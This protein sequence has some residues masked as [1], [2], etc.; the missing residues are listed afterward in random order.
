MSVAVGETNFEAY[1]WHC[2][3][4]L[5]CMHFSR[6]QAARYSVQAICTWDGQP[7]W[8][9]RPCPAAMAVYHKSCSSFCWGNKTQ[10]P[11][12]HGGNRS[13]NSH[14][15]LCLRRRSPP[16]PHPHC[17][18]MWSMTLLLGWLLSGRGRPQGPTLYRI[19]S[20]ETQ[21]VSPAVPNWIGPP[22]AMTFLPPP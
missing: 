6:F 3:F 13:T 5:V 20:G 7:W 14:M 8:E 22:W 2:W 17:F 1:E 16:T 11:L 9:G 4:F 18:S 10:T 12:L 21:P 19:F 15:L